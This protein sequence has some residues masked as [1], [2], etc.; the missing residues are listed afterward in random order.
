M[1]Q[2]TFFEGKWGARVD[3]LDEQIPSEGKVTD[4]TR[5][6]LE[7]WRKL[8]NVYYRHHNDGDTFVAKLRH[9]A[10][11]YDTTISNNEASLEALA[12]TVFVAAWKEYKQSTNRINR[13]PIR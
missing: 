7:D 4:K 10:K 6:V 8:Q 3:I 5:P 2:K 12:D 1:T 11:R 13:P 9:M